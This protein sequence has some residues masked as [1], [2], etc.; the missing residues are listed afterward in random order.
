MTGVTDV[1]AVTDIAASAGDADFI[2]N[3]VY[4]FADGAT[5]SAGAGT[6]TITTYTTLAEVASFVSDS[7]TDNTVGASN[8]TVA[9]DE[10]IFVI[11][12]LVANLTYVY[13]FVE[14]GTLTDASAADIVSAG[15]L[16]LI[17]TVTEDAA[18]AL[19]AADII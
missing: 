8:D 6:A 13:H 3:E 4:V 1:V 17:A 12:D 9:G 2:D 19:V 5:A 7:F 11:N 10:A 15:E 18:G 16:T 14:D